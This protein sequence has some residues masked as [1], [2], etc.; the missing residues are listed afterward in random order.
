MG[1]NIRQDVIRL[2]GEIAPEWSQ[3]MDEYVDT[4]H[5]LGRMEENKTRQVI[6]QFTK[7]QHRDGIWRMTK[8]SQICE[9]AGI[10]F[11]EDLTKA[12]KLEREKLWPQIL[13]YIVQ[14]GLGQTSSRGAATQLGAGQVKNQEVTRRGEES[15]V[16]GCQLRRTATGE[17]EQVHRDE[18]TRLQVR[19]SGERGAV[20]ELF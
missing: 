5:R 10:G 11:T 1:E 14:M 13:F 15:R 16:P 7:R 2:L 8:K 3:N 17:P 4:I 18:E 19:E 12:D 20:L 6:V 9:T